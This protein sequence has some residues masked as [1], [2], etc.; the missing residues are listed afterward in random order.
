M[1]LTRTDQEKDI[2][3]KEKNKRKSEYYEG[4]ANAPLEV[5]ITKQADRNCNLFNYIHDL[6]PEYTLKKFPNKFNETIKYF[7]IIFDGWEKNSADK[8]KVQKVRDW[9]YEEL[10]TLKKDFEDHF[11]IESQEGYTTI[12]NLLNKFPAAVSLLDILLEEPSRG[13]LVFKHDLK[14]LLRNRSIKIQKNLQ[15]DLLRF[16]KH[17]KLLA[18]P[19][20]LYEL[21]SKRSHAHSSSAK[22][23]H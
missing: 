2:S 4:I 6:P 9:F 10:V 8:T 15:K 1:L 23:A 13:V 7:K 3:E 14:T 18:D 22:T 12:P 5:V 20:D 11:P 19:L 21:T 16:S 17:S